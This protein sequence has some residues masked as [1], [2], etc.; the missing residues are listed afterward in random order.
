MTGPS[1]R[2]L[3]VAAVAS[4]SGKTI[5]TIGL[6][7]ALRACGHRVAAAKCGPDYIDP[8]FLTAASGDEAVNLDPWAMNKDRIAA[9]LAAQAHGSDFV[10]IE[11][12][13]GLYDGGIGGAGS[14]ADLARL[15]GLPV[16]LV[17]SA[18]SLAQSAAAIA[19]GF[20]Q[21]AQE[22]DVAGAIVNG[23]ASKRHEAL[24]RE[25]FE[26][27]DVPLLGLVRRDPALALKSRHLGLVQ[28]GEHEALG[29][30]IESAGRVIADG[31][32][33]DRL[34]DLASPVAGG[35]DGKTAG[36][37]SL[38]PLGQNLTI[39]RD[40]AFA[41]AYRHLLADWQAAGASLSFFS[42][43]D[44]EPPETHAD[45]VYLPGGY[46]ELYAG[47]L[48][49][50]DR[51]KAGLQAAA[52]RGALIYGECGG[53][54]ALGEALIDGDGTRHAMAGLLPLVSSFEQ[55]KLNLGYR[56]VRPLGNAPFPATLSAHEFHYSTI[57]SEGA[58]DR[59]FAAETVDGQAL[60][61]IGM[62]RGRVMGSFAHIIDSV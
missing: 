9:R 34:I 48:A 17:V 40:T 3:T 15:T 30:L 35:S 8:R 39:A 24:I 6:I 16:F 19:A 60:G 28:A 43:L 37:L 18:Q 53:Y 21:L 10:V 23:V 12:V 46:P 29:R 44:D 51:F 61:E 58:G 2:G 50:A 1:P 22:F 4:N 42:P 14:T 49:G 54:M 57:V 32:A 38:P 26:A 27:T 47:Q 7:A 62:R 55:R 33:L 56:L 20:A 41:F 11:G 13:M 59:L 31:V 45:A 25:G 5:V 36:G 52:A